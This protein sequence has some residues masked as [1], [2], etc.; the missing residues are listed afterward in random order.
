MTHVVTDH[1]EQCRYTECV[2]VCPVACFRGD[3]ERLFID[4]DLCVDC[5]ACVPMCPVHAIVDSFDLEDDQQ[6]WLDVNARR[7][8]E[9]PT[10]RERAMPLPTAAERRASLGH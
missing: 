7:S 2:T 10:V 9:L 4:P 1:C 8:K 6:I 5:G 3:G